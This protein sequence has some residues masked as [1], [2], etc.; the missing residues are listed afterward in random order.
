MLAV[1]SG[2]AGVCTVVCMPV[3]NGGLRDPYD[4]GAVEQGR[5]GRYTVQ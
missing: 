4:S 2:Q 5:L 3:S 1:N